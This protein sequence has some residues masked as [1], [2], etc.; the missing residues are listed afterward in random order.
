MHPGG[1]DHQQIAVEKPN[2]PPV[3]RLTK[4]KLIFGTM[5]HNIDSIE[6]MGL[7]MKFGYARTST[8]D[9]QADFEAQVRDL[10]DASCGKVFTDQVSTGGEREQLDAA[11]DFIRGGDTLVVTKLD[12]LARST[13]HLVQITDGLEAKGACLQILNI[14]VDTGTPKGRLMLTMLE[15][16]AQFERE[17]MLERQREGISKA[18]SEGKYKGRKPTARAKT[19]DV[20]RLK[21]NGVG[22]TEISRTLGIGRASVYRIIN[23]RKSGRLY[24]RER[25]LKNHPRQKE[26]DAWAK[27]AKFPSQK[28]KGHRGYVAK[29]FDFAAVREFVVKYV[30]D[31]GRF[32]K[33]FHEVPKL[34]K[35]RIRG[36]FRVQFPDE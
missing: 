30:D 34:K 16:I 25:L 35:Y 28:Y 19:K 13:A 24:K 20:L 4:V 5:Y 15:A 18:K 8:L 33:D 2:F 10:K 36:E 26:I 3:Y 9:Q 12:R 17:I 14:G 21:D 27:R 6:K 1:A 23:D 11:L 22:A 7:T 32:P 31:T 29:S